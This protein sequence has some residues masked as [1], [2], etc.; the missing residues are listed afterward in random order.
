MEKQVGELAWLDADSLVLE[1][2]RASRDAVAPAVRWVVPLDLVT[3]LEV[4]QGLRPNPD[5]G[6][7]VGAGIGLG[8]GTLLVGGTCFDEYYG[9]I[10]AVMLPLNTLGG[11][12]LGFVL[13]GLSRTERWIPVTIPR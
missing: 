11:G 5:R 4:S 3:E 2:T 9:E 6:F 8:L 1:A 13:G 12:L 7:L 10:C